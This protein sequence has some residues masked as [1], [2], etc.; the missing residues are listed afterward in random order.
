MVS[1]PLEILG[2]IFS[3]TDRLHSIVTDLV[4]NNSQ[5]ILKI[6]QFHEITEDA[7]VEPLLDEATT[8]ICQLVS[9]SKFVHLQS[10]TGKIR[11]QSNHSG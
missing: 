11:P 7:K 1:A 9:E 5:T 6:L 10:Q 4:K 2:D 8:S 3:S